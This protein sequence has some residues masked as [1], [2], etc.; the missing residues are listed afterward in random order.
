MHTWYDVAN[1]TEWIQEKLASLDKRLEDA[2]DENWNSLQEV[3]EM[4]EVSI[5]A[6]EEL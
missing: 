2:R 3:I 4:L 1:T 5:S 6:G